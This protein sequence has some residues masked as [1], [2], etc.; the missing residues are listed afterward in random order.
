MKNIF[1][2]IFIAIV[3][4]NVVAFAYFIY[5]RQAIHHPERPDRVDS[6]DFVDITGKNVIFQPKGC[7]ILR[8]SGMDCHF[9]EGKFAHNWLVLEKQLTDMGCKSYE[10]APNGYDVVLDGDTSKRTIL[11]A[12]S[13]KFATQT[14]FNRTPTTEIGYNHRVI[15]RQAGVITISNIIHCTHMVR[16]LEGQHRGQ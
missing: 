12:V 13:P 11:L 2:K 3:F 16:K 7:W 8:Y 1:F 5:F 15:W 6:G 9:C 10:I 4:F 14:N